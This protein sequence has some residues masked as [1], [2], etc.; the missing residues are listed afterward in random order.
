MFN[1]A[2]CVFLYPAAR[3]NPLAGG[4]GGGGMGGLLSAIQ[5][6]KS[7][8]KTETKDKSAPPVAG[9]VLDGGPPKAPSSSA[10]STKPALNIPGLGAPSAG[11]GK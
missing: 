3:P 5:A 10:P 2:Y 6:G 9:Q 11:S 4:G 8:K 1:L 7:L